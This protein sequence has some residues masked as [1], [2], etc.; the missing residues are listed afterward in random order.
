LDGA[1]TSNITPFNRYASDDS[2][3]MEATLIPMA[4][5]SGVRLSFLLNNKSY[6][7][8]LPPAGGSTA[9]LKGKRYTYKVLFD[10]AQITL[11]GHLS[12][13]G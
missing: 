9:L 11:E 7:A 2:V 5:A 13:W 6:S 3:R 8:P 1:G 10:E 4:D 12:A